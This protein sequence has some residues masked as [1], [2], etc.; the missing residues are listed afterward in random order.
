MLPLDLL[1]GSWDGSVRLWALDPKLR[2]FR[3]LFNIPAPGFVNSLQLLTPDSKRKDGAVDP[4]KWRRRGGLGGMG[5]LASSTSR[6]EEGEGEDDDAA[7]SGEVAG[8]ETAPT[9]RGRKEAIPPI[10]I[11]GLGQEP[12]MGRWM[13]IKEARNGALVVPLSFVS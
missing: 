13:R 6:E 8:K 2:S 4:D 7:Q 1:P 11:V 5:A 10:L 3:A 9:A 12:K